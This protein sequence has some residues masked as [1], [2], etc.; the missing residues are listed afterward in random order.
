MGKFKFVI[1]RSGAIVPFNADRIANVI[2]RAAV[3]V[4]GRDKEKAEELA[5]HVITVLEEIYEEGYRPH[6]EEIQDI[7]EKVLIKNGHSHFF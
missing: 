3:A 5:K 4:G 6:V 7:I 1:K 2:Y